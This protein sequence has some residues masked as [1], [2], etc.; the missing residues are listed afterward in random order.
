MVCENSY[1][2]ENGLSSLS[3]VYVDYNDNL[4]TRAIYQSISPL[5]AYN[6]ALL[7]SLDELILKYNHLA[8][9][10]AEKYFKGDKVILEIDYNY[11]AMDIDSVKEVLGAILA[12]D[13]LLAVTTELP[14]NLEEFK[15]IELQ[16]YECEERK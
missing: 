7:A 14:V 15:N 8:G 6:T 13:S 12:E 9:I 16:E 2:D 5:E 1:T 10:K 4:V 11:L 3:K